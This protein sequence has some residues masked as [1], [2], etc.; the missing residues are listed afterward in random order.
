LLLEGIVLFI[1]LW[2]YARKERKPAQVSAVFLVG[3][4]AARFTAEYFREP[5]SFLGVLALHMTMGQWL[6]VPMIL[7]GVL[8][9][10]WAETRVVPPRAAPAQ[11]RSTAR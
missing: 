11:R 5:D 4:G 6:C 1:V 7:G 9:W 3:Y 8:L 10:V 2:L